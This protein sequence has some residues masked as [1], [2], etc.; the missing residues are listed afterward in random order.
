MVQT[1]TGARTT[2]WLIVLTLLLAACTDS[3]GPD[4]TETPPPELTFS[5]LRAVYSMSPSTMGILA[6]KSADDAVA[7]N[8]WC[9]PRQEW[10]D[11]ALEECR[12]AAED[13]P[14]GT[15]SA[16]DGEILLIAPPARAAPFLWT[17]PPSRSNPFP[18]E[19]DFTVD[20][21]VKVEQ[22]GGHG[23]GIYMF[24]WDPAETKGSNSPFR[25]A[26]MRIWADAYGRLRVYLPG[27]MVRV[28]DA[29][30][31][32][33]YR[34]AYEN[35]AYTLFIDG[36]HAVGPIITDVRPT[37]IWLGNPI[38]A[39]WGVGD[40]SDFRVS[41]LT[42]STPAVEAMSVPVDVKPGSCPT[43]V[44]LRGR[45]VVPVAVAGTAEL[46]V[47]QIDPATIKLAGVA[48]LRWAYEDVTTPVDPYTGKTVDDC[49]DAG[50]DGIMDVALKFSKE[51]LAG[52]ISAEAP[53]GEFTL[54]VTGS[55][56][57]EF[58]GTPIE[59]EDVVLISNRW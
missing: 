10:F 4:V 44:N 11:P 20:I 37:A 40:W 9:N 42:V 59:G 15:V 45:G 1:S 51:E 13:P 56:L 43:P 46:D 29:L 38:F 54:T 18:E 34:L 30:A 48:P 49:T 52:A 2:I 12:G 23:T 47:S 5:P 24:P 16:N 21:R 32:H 31:P 57:P 3:T 19:G 7:G 53:Q 22:L 14:F 28:P 36:E 41:Q 27:A 17:G 35:G 6:E 33:S 25:P 39:D 8:R 58:G 26:V 55:L 50:S